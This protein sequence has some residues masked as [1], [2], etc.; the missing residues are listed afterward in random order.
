MT[1]SWFE[2]T[3][4][5]TLTP[6]WARWRLKPPAYRLFVQPFV[7]VQWKETSKLRVTCHWEGNPPVTPQ[8]ANN[9]E[10]VSI[11]WRHHEDIGAVDWHQTQNITIRPGTSRQ[12]LECITWAH[13]LSFT[14][15]K[16]RLCSANHR[17]GYFSNLACDWLSILWTHSEQETEN[18]P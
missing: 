15:S 9:A 7:Q 11:W 14:W 10:N 4:N 3:P 8:R 13:F 12:F 16:L 6:Y 5:I 2:V 17:A 1:S 18:G